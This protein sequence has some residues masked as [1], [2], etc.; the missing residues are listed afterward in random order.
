MSSPMVVQPPHPLP[1]GNWKEMGV[2]I[3]GATPRCAV[4]RLVPI[5]LEQIPDIVAVPRRKWSPEHQS[6]SGAISPSLP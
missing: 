5:L 1:V 6:A 3:P 4:K 2:N